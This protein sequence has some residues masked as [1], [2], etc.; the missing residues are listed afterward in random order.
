MTSLTNFLCSLT[1][2][3]N[4]CRYSELE[5]IRVEIR[6]VEIIVYTCIG[7]IRPSGKGIKEDIGC[8][9]L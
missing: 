2:W 5:D 8:V 9:T 4:F 6:L 3:Y 1:K 7:N